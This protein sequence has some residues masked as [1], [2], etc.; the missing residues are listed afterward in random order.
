MP[1]RERERERKSI[2]INLVGL[3]SLISNEDGTRAEIWPL[4]AFEGFEVR[5]T[6]VENSGDNKIESRFL[7]SRKI[8]RILP[9]SSQALFVNIR[10]VETFGALQKRDHRI[11]L[12]IGGPLSK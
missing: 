3:S 11:L 2:R 1:E 9:D 7:E 12:V 10:T 8:C 5:H 4:L 6:V